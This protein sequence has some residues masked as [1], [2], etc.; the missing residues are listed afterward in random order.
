MEDWRIVEE[1][2]CEDRDSDRAVR[3]F[4]AAHP[5]ITGRPERL[6]RQRSLG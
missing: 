1:A 2:Y 6:G 3:K 4:E 5:E